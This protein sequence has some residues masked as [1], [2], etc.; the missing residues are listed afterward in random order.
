MGLRN[1]IERDLQNKPHVEPVVLSGMTA[2][3]PDGTSNPGSSLT[4][5]TTEEK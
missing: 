4:G 3:H 2:I 1:G 5:Q